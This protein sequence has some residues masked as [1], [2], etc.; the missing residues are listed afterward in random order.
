VDAR[1]SSTSVLGARTFWMNPDNLA[2]AME[3]ARAYL[4]NVAADPSIRDLEV[5]VH[6]AEHE[7]PALAIV[8]LATELKADAIAI[9]T[10]GHGRAARAML[11]SAADKVLRSSPLPLLM[12]RPA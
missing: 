8:E 11:G 1:H 9:A 6:V 12:Q 7:A 5:S 3:K 2:G 4:E 10:H